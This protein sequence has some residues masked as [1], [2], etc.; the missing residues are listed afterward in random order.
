MALFMRRLARF[1]LVLLISLTTLAVGAASVRAP[2]AH[3]AAAE[4]PAPVQAEPVLT[5]VTPEAVADAPVEPEPVPAPPPTIAP[6]DRIKQIP[7]LMY[8][9]IGEVNNNNYVRRSEFEAQV[10]WLA[11]NGYHAVTLA[12]VYA[13]INDFRPLPPKPVVITFDDGYATFRGTAVPIL[14]E[15]GYTATAFITTGLIGRPEHMTWA[16][17]AELP[18]LGFEIGSHSVTHPDLRFLSGARLTRELV[19]ARRELQERTG[20]RVD[21][22]CYPAGKFNDQTPEAIKAA[23]YL[24]AVTTEYG[25]VTLGQSPFLW[26]RIRIVRGETPGSFARKIRNATGEGH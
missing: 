22:F 25:P 14:R 26:S 20:A 17:V 8:H 7:V 18:G 23:G 15:Q 13:H 5:P 1:L 21:F 6:E 2:G 24:G 9:E 4:V 11:E 16:E 10:K 3:L 12:Q 19:E